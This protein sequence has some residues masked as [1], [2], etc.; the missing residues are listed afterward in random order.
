MLQ[1][2]GWDG[3]SPTPMPPRKQGWGVGQSS[4]VLLV[5]AATCATHGL[6][7]LDLARPMFQRRHFYI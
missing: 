4:T 5:A 2:W 3:F 7:H 6:D 1:V